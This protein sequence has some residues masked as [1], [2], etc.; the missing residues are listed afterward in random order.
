MKKLILLLLSLCLL[1]IAACSSQP[2]EAAAEPK[3]PVSTQEPVELPVE[4]EPEPVNRS[5]F[6][7]EEIS[8]DQNTCQAFG[9]IIENTASARP[10]SALGLADLVYENAVETYT[11]TRFL[12]IFASEHPT[13]VGPVRSSRIPFVR[14][15]QE[16]GLPYA[17]YGSAATG[18][19]DAKSLLESIDVPIR[20][21]GHKGINHEFYSRD[22][23][24]KAPHNAYFNAKD[25]LVKIPELEY[26]KLFDFDERTNIDQQDASTVSLRYASSNQV[27]Y[28]YDSVNKSYLRFIND[29][30]MLDAYMDDQIRV[31]NIIVLHAPHTTAEKAQYVLVDFL[32]EGKAEY[33]VNGKYEEGIWK[34][35][36]YEERT[37]YFDSTGNPIV[38]LPGNTWIQV[39]HGKVEITKE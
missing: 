8:G 15:I 12:A 16:W 18:Q 38:L 2:E 9:I 34:K 10:Q 11:I 35:A 21:D 1:I 29:K 19:G 17:H 23:A 6:N 31:T 27:R 24:R 13:K 28:E 30:P 4:P 7:G 3:E 32:G 26:K 22:S 37:E 14:M 39:V 20:F 25:A 5:V 36:S 33:F